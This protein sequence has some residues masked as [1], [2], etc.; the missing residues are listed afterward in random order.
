[1]VV[2]RD[3]EDNPVA[4]WDPTRNRY[5]LWVSSVLNM[6]NKFSVQSWCRVAELTMCICARLGR[7]VAPI[8]IDDAIIF[9]IGD[10]LTESLEF[11]EA[12]SECLGLELSNRPAACQSSL[13]LKQVKILGLH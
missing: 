11:Y 9:G 7:I 6:G 12:L 4:A 3:P 2:A 13:E 5:R 1:M 10:G 8:Y